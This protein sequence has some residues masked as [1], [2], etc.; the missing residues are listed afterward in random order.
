MKSFKFFHGYDDVDEP[1]VRGAFQRLMDSFQ[2]LDRMAMEVATARLNDPRNNYETLEDMTDWDVT[3]SDG[4][5]E[6]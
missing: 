2:E 1:F 6:E 5:G 4:L 3:I